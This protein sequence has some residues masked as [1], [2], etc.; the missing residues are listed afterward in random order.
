MGGSQVT[1][2][3]RYEKALAAITKGEARGW[4]EPGHWYPTIGK[5]NEWE[6]VCGSCGALM[7]AIRLKPRL[8]PYG[9]GHKWVCEDGCGTTAGFGDVDFEKKEKTL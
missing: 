6:G 7:P 2:K 3:E 8:L 4:K 5:P 1:A 9:R